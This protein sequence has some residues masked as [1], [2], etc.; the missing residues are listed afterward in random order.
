LTVVRR[1][2]SSAMSVE[3]LRDLV[4]VVSAGRATSPSDILDPDRPVRNHGYPYS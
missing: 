4:T 3:L 1:W 2:T